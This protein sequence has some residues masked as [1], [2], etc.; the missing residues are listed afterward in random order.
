V[1]VTLRVPND[2]GQKVIPLRLEGLATAD[3]RE[4]R[5]EAVPADNMMQ[6]FAYQHLV[7]AQRWVAAIEPAP[8]KPPAWK[9]ETP[10][11]LKL[12]VGGATT[13]RVRSTGRP[14]AGQVQVT[15]ADPPRG[16]SVQ[17]VTVADG[18]LEIVVQTDAET[19]KVGLKGNLVFT[20]TM[21]REPPKDAPAGAPAPP[22]GAANQRVP[23][24]SLPAMPFEIVAG[25]KAKT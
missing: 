14:P 17:K 13:I 7:P 23:L 6:A 10:V 8:P 11:P 9:I 12:A 24:G 16:V 2:P 5:R 3:G 20:A 18:L 21:Q 15:L 22:P 4:I 1:Q 25:D 19:A